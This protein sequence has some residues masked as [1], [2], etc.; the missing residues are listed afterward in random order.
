M[1]LPWDCAPFNRKA[2][3]YRQLI[4]GQH[5]SIS[6][7]GLSYDELTLLVFPQF[8]HGL[9]HMLTTVPYS[10]AAGINNVEWDAVGYIEFCFEFA[11][12]MSNFGHKRYFVLEL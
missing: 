9:Q 7:Y 2:S 1:R 6:L 12:Q 10:D 5:F 4:D 3:A 11:E 8:G